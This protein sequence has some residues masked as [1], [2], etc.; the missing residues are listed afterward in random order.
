AVNLFARKLHHLFGKQRRGDEPPFGLTAVRR[1]HAGYV[2]D[3]PRRHP[4]H[5]LAHDGV[6]LAFG[7]GLV[8]RDVFQRERMNHE[9]KLVHAD[10]SASALSAASIISLF[11]R[12]FRCKVGPMSS[13]RVGTP[14]S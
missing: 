2:N 9:A 13:A 14:K 11:S 4:F 5:D 10:F 7:A 6:A 3:V 1:P 12:T 8:A